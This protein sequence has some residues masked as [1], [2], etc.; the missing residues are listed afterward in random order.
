MRRRPRQPRIDGLETRLL[1]TVGHPA[2]EVA[3]VAGSPRIRGQIV[4]TYE[5]DGAS[6]ADVPDRYTLAGA[7]TLR[8]GRK[9]RAEA[10]AAEG[11]VLGTGFTIA[12]RSTGAVTLTTT[13][14]RVTLRLRGPLQRGF[15]PPPPQLHYTIAPGSGTG[16]FAGRTGGGTARLQLTRTTPGDGPDAGRFVLHFT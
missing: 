12:G 1:L 4:G 15:Q 6:A 11:F 9:G 13:D 7:G 14:G 10:A 16:V 3:P 5:N 8:V 2:A